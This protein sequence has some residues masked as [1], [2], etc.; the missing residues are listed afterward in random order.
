[1]PDKSLLSS[2]A[3]TYGECQTYSDAGVVES[4]WM[5]SSSCFIQF[6][7]YFKRPD[8]I[9]IDWTN[10]KMPQ[11]LDQTLSNTA[12]YDGTAHLWLNAKKFETN[13]PRSQTALGSVGYLLAAAAAGSV[14]LSLMVPPI[15][16]PQVG[17]L[18]TLT[19]LENCRDAAP[20]TDA[21]KYSSAIHVEDD[22]A[23]YIIFVDA[24]R[25][26]RR[27]DSET[28]SAREKNALITYTYQTVSLNVDI[29][30]EIFER[31]AE[32]R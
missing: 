12:F 3:V 6:R 7:T 13:L 22:A 27:I 17:V 30:Q 29:P 14:G 25:L 15:L 23:N 5:G 20:S 2:I 16:T 10:Q 18:T 31:P 26:I 9:R 11:A 4:S 1:M 24:D 21:H 8:F 19:D 28:K 32:T